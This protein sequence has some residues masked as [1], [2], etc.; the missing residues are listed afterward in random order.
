[1]RPRLPLLAALMLIT[2]P[3]GSE[4]LSGHDDLAAQRPLNLSL[5]RERL[6]K[7]ATP[8]NVN[9]EDPVIHDLRQEKSG[10]APATP[11]YGTGFE[12]REHGYAG[13]AP[14]FSAPGDAS[15][16]TLQGGAARESVGMGRRR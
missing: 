9:A 8:S 16:G 4:T 14:R 15:G 1:M 12:A 13:A 11:R 5:P 7:P 6:S 10:I 3:C 2:S